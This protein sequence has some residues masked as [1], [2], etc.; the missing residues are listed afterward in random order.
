MKFILRR[1][2]QTS[3]RRNQKHIDTITCV[4]L[5][6]VCNLPDSTGRWLAVDRED[7]VD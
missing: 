6:I 2:K 4:G 3:R 7:T 1:R 5:L